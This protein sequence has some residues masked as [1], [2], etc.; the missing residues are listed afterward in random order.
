MTIGSPLSG[1]DNPTLMQVGCECVPAAGTTE[2]LLPLI[3]R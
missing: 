1:V 2:V 3:P